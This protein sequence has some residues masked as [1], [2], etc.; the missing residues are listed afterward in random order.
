[1]HSIQNEDEKFAFSSQTPKRDE[2]LSKVEIFGTIWHYMA[3]F[4]TTIQYLVRPCI[5]NYL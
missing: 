3:L 5:K 2:I 4:G 1:M